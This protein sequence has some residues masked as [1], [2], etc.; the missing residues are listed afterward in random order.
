MGVRMWWARPLVCGSACVLGVWFFAWPL[1]A[2]AGDAELL[3]AIELLDRGDA[4]AALTTLAPMLT[5]SSPDPLCPDARFVAARAALLAGRYALTLAHLRD[6]EIDR[7]LLAGEIWGLRARAQRGLGRWR[8]ARAAWEQAL[9]IFHDTKS[10]TR[11]KDNAP[12][13]IEAR[14]GIADAFF[15]YNELDAARTAYEAVT[16]LD[17]RSE[18]ALA[19][20]YNLGRIAEMQGRYADAAEHYRA[21]ALRHV[22]HPLHEAALTRLTFLAET[23]LGPAPTFGQQLY[24][25]DRLLLAHSFEEAKGTLDHIAALAKTGADKQALQL[26]LGEL[27]Y[28]E[29]DYAKAIEIFRGLAKTTDRRWRLEFEQWLAR[30]LSASGDTAGAIAVH[31]AIRTREADSAAARE[32]LFKAAWLAYNGADHA[33]AIKLFGEFVEAFPDDASASD[34][35]WFLAWNAYRQ[36]DLPTAVASLKKLRERFGSGPLVMRASYWEGR[37]AVAMGQARTARTRFEA[38][39]AKQPYDYYGLLARKRLGELDRLADVERHAALYASLDAPTLPALEAPASAP[40]TP[41]VSPVPTRDELPW[42]GG[43]AP[44]A[45]ADMPWGASV[46]DWQSPAG[47]RVQALLRVGLVEPAAQVVER[48]TPFSGFDP[49]EVNYARARLLYALRAFGPSY[50]LAGRAFRS[51]TSGNVTPESRRFFQLAYPMAYMPQIEAAASEFKVSP[52]VLLA[53]MRQESAFNRRARS[54]ASASGLLQ[55]IPRTGAKIAERLGVRDYTFAALQDPKTNIRFAAWYVAEL[56]KKYH[57]H[58]ALAVGSYNGGPRAMSHWLTLRAGSATD[59]FVE[60]IPFR[61]TRQYVKT[62]LGNLTAYDALYGKGE[63]A[64][65]E[66][67]P[68]DCLDN[69]DF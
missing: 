60:D 12:P 1:S 45:K 19:A 42:G 41:S 31:L 30:T 18:V 58:L 51:A 33:Q 39:V 63:L 34:A 36:G 5:A 2:H 3:A 47:Q 44:L 67:I 46:F 10:V 23:G 68:A 56:L 38:V 43:L 69:I 55:I 54:T 13:A 7:P 8:H 35:L 49:L 48:M 64:L 59:E 29:E 57:D 27:A 20:H 4:E 40:T 53:L 61:E 52:Y 6:L 50:R 15:A 16:A 14:A 24:Y 32:A 37:I 28:R 17:R 9:E 65:P 11:A 21:L 62:V 26:R 22:A 66:S 25:V